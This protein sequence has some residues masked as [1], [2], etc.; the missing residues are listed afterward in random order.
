[1]DLQ[2]LK[3]YFCDERYCFKECNCTQSSIACDTQSTVNLTRHDKLRW[4]A[5]RGNI[6]RCWQRENKLLCSREKKKSNTQRGK[7]LE[8][9]TLYFISSQAYNMASKHGASLVLLPLKGDPLC[10]KEKHTHANT[11]CAHVFVRFTLSLY[12]SLG[13]KRKALSLSVRRASRLIEWESV[14]AR[15]TPSHGNQ[16]RNQN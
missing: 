6:G 16:K 3:Y 2:G 11:M 9:G 14:R 10:E 1:M 7:V 12:I 13:V 4:M 5:I 15:K 8:R